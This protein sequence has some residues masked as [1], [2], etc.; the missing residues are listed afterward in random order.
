MANDL[1]VFAEALAQKPFLVSA[2]RF[3][4]CQRLLRYNKRSLIG[5]SEL[6][7][8]DPGLCTVVLRKVNRVRSRSKNPLEITSIISAVNLLGEN[9]MLSLISNISLLEHKI[10]DKNILSDYYQLIDRSFHAAQYSKNWAEIRNDPVPDE[11]GIAALLREIGEIALC[12]YHHDLFRQIRD[13]ASEQHVSL[14]YASIEVLGFS[15]S[16]LS[17]LLAKFWYLPKVVRDGMDPTRSDRNR[18]L[19]VMLASECTR[20][21]EFGWYHRDMISCELVIADYL[22]TSFDQVCRDLHQTTILISRQRTLLKPSKFAALLAQH[23]YEVRE[24]A[25]QVSGPSVAAD[26]NASQDNPRVNPNKVRSAK[27]YTQCIQQIKQAASGGAGVSELVKIMVRGLHKGANM[28]RVAFAMFD[29]SGE[30]LR[31][32]VAKGF[33]A[34]LAKAIVFPCA[35]YTLFSALLQSPKSIWINAGNLKKVTPMI[36]DDFSQQVLTGDFVCTS[37]FRG[38]RALGLVY[39]DCVGGDLPIDNRACQQVK[40]LVLFTGRAITLA[41]DKRVSATKMPEPEPKSISVGRVTNK[42]PTDPTGVED[43]P[44]S[45]S[46]EGAVGEVDIQATLAH[47]QA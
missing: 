24:C 43:Q 23:P 8:S 42:A 26:G 47:R 38:D 16:Q 33:D 5:A 32:K 20:L 15:L 25:A 41:E 13:R 7:M 21:A 39:C 19:G 6:I 36:P 22:N 35:D 17:T 44:L 30:N 4:N 46:L 14:S 2:N 18:A 11:V 29:A 12:T 31:I 45:Q 28:H 9:A 34:R 40:S 10:T 27:I 1:H 3:A 37:L